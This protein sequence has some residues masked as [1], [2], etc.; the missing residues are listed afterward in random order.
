MGTQKTLRQ[1]LEELGSY[2]YDH[3]DYNV[4]KNTIKK[5]E[6]ENFVNCYI[7]GVEIIKNGENNTPILLKGKAD[8]DKGSTGEEMLFFHGYQLYDMTGQTGEWVLA[9]FPSKE[10]LEKHIL[11]EGGYLNIYCTEMLV[12]LDG[13]IQPF[14]VE[15]F[16]DNGK[17]IT[18]DKD[19]F[20]TELDIKGMQ[21]RIS[22]KWL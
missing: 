22:V 9:T 10:A 14:E 19:L 4:I 18:I 6:V 3:G 13:E 12:Y 21:E 5:D 8:A 2:C 16:G 20:D 1:F 7:K 17:Y 15:F 11:G